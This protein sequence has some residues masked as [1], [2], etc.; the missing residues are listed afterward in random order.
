MAGMTITPRGRGSRNGR[1]SGLAPDEFQNVHDTDKSTWDQMMELFLTPCN[2]SPRESR[3]SNDEE[4]DTQVVTREQPDEED[5][6][7]Y[8]FENVESTVCRGD[9]GTENEAK[10]NELDGGSIHSLRRDNSLI[11]RE[12]V[13][14]DMSTDGNYQEPRKDDLH[15][16]WRTGKI[17]K[18]SKQNAPKRTTKTREPLDGNPDLLDYVFQNT[19]S[20]VCGESITPEEMI[21]N[22]EEEED[23]IIGACSFHD[24]DPEPPTSKTRKAV[25]DKQK[26][27]SDLLDYVFQNTESFVCGESIMPEEMIMDTDED[28]LI[29]GACSFRDQDPESLIYAKEPEPPTQTKGEV[30]IQKVEDERKNKEEGPDVLD[31]VFEN[32]ESFVCGDERIRPQGKQLN[33]A[34]RAIKE[35]KRLVFCLPFDAC[36]RFCS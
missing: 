7:D 5:L 20:F 4:P 19:E 21:M 28:N 30:E 25:N 27:N 15:F 9:A 18:N 3:L 12:D 11:D 24:Q 1:Q 17:V 2:P 34:A 32:T 13:E 22:L 23:E 36:V 10:E 31:F 26:G 35:R 14:S 33:A 29:I 16:E 8:V 6:L